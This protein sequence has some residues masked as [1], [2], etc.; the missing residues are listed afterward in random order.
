[1]ARFKFYST[2]KW[3][4]C[5]DTYYHQAKG[6]CERCLARGLIVPGEIVHHIQEI[7][8]NNINNP[9]IVY[10]FDNLELVCRK[11]HAQLHEDLWQNRSGKSNYSNKRYKVDEFGRVILKK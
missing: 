1:M 7:N 4:K 5:R 10:G 11:C 3:Q 6:L 8:E 9:A 2:K